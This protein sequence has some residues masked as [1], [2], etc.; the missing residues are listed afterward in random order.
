MIKTIEK[1]KSIY[2]ANNNAIFMLRFT[3]P[4][5][6]VPS[7]FC[8]LAQDI[9]YDGLGSTGCFR[10]APKSLE[11]LNENFVEMAG[12][13][14]HYKEF[15]EHSNN[16]VVVAFIMRET[17]PDVSL[18]DELNIF[19]EELVEFCDATGSSVEQL[20]ISTMYSNKTPQ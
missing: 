7:Q 8:R 9:L 5:Q 15:F 4:E 6:I 11:H 3:F 18:V 20:D 12:E 2:K 14:A 13:E 1:N 16:E 19:P 10:L 17:D